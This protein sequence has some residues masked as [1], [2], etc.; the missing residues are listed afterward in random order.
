ME[1]WIGGPM[2]GIKSFALSL[3]C[4]AVC[5]H[6]NKRQTK[7]ETDGNNSVIIWLAFSVFFM[8]KS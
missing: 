7:H 6:L 5:I 2:F 4:L 1:F 8:S 3:E